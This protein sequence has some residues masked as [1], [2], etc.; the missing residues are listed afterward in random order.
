MQSGT[1]L[2]LSSPF[3]QTGFSAQPSNTAAESSLTATQPCF[4]GDL[5]ILM[6]G[7]NW[8]RPGIWKCGCWRT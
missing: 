8:T 2:N 6:K 4:G 3:T 7:M 5:P 1:E